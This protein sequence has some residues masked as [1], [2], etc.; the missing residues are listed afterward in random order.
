LEQNGNLQQGVSAPGFYNA[1]LSFRKRRRGAVWDAV[2]PFYQAFNP[3]AVKWA[4]AMTATIFRQAGYPVCK[5]AS[6]EWR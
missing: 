3:D 1:L 5:G 4:E 6:A 2:D